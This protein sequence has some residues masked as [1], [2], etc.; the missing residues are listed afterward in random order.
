MKD[1]EKDALIRKLQS[2]LAM[3]KSVLKQ[4]ESRGYGRSGECCPVCKVTTQYHGLKTIQ[5]HEDGCVIA[6]VLN[7]KV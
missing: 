1:Y 5:E 6:E 4:V 3:A 7:Y 2:Q